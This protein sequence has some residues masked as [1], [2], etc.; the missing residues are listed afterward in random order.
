MNIIEEFISDVLSRHHIP[1]DDVEV[2]KVWP[3]AGHNA[4]TVVVNIGESY[5][6]SFIFDDGYMVL[7]RSS[8]R[9]PDDVYDVV[10]EW[11]YAHDIKSYLEQKVGIIRRGHVFETLYGRGQVRELPSGAY[12]ICLGFDGSEYIDKEGTT[13]TWY[14][15]EEDED[16]I[17]DKNNPIWPV[18]DAL[19]EELETGNWQTGGRNE[20]RVF[21]AYS[22]CLE[23]WKSLENIRVYDTHCIITTQAGKTHKAIR[24]DDEF[25]IALAASPLFRKIV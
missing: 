23:E 15:K 12:E 10:V 1:H 21:Q 3:K 5:N 7:G 24:G 25:T 22:A 13:Y 4:A 9:V 6:I 16:I 11:A 17:V 20:Y 14:F 2:V 8:V 18:V 19:F